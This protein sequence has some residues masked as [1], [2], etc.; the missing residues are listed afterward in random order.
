MAS[1]GLLV[2]RAMGTEFLPTC[3]RRSIRNQRPQK[4]CK[5]SEIVRSITFYRNRCIVILRNWDF[6]GHDSNS[7]KNP[8]TMSRGE[9][10]KSSDDALEKA[11]REVKRLEISKTWTQLEGFQG[12]RNSQSLRR[13][14]QVSNV[15]VPHGLAN[16]KKRKTER[17]KERKAT[18]PR[19][20]RYDG[21]RF[22]E[23]LSKRSTRLV[24]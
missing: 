15:F 3:I 5:I 7:K 2:T 14:K 16:G 10:K 23:I 13:T 8:T 21:S 1:Q 12:R 9:G 19:G 4:W 17:T 18:Q 24:S 6:P 11:R 22:R 20:K